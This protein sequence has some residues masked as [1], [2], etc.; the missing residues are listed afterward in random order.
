MLDESP[1]THASSA[2]HSD[3]AQAQEESQPTISKN[4]MKRDKREEYLR[5]KKK[6][7]K[8][9]EK[10]KKLEKRL[11]NPPK[12]KRSIDSDLGNEVVIK[13]SRK[14][15]KLEAAELHRVSCNANFS[16]IIDCGWETDHTDSSLKSLTQQIMFSYGANKR[17]SNPVNM[18]L[19]GLGPRIKARLSA[20]MYEHWAEV[21]LSDEDYIQDTA[22]FTTASAAAPTPSP[23]V[24]HSVTDNNAAEAVL[25][26]SSSSLSFTPVAPKQLVYLTSDAE[27]T[28]ESLDPSCAYI[29]GG[30][31][32]RNRLKGATYNKAKAQGVRTAKLPIKENFSLASTH[33]LTVNHVFEML[34]HFGQCG[35]W[36][37]AI[38]RVIPKRKGLAVKPEAAAPAATAPDERPVGGAAEQNAVCEAAAGGDDEE[39]E[40]CAATSAGYGEGGNDCN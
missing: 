33:I 18:H 27:E 31:V 20:V 32:D 37:E 38:E 2:P 3:I 14:E 17:H 6:E 40:E 35:S 29:I 9:A 26:P 24:G 5:S 8:E 7:K 25:V 13:R 4:Q 11:A 15:C 36:P 1:T 12:E 34:L 23:S 16:V 10:K 19:T 39:E 30:I 22:R 28:L 21:T